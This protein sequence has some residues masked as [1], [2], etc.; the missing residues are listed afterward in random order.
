M[1]RYSQP[2]K[3]LL[4]KPVHAF[5]ARFGRHRLGSGGPA[6]WVLMY[7]RILP[8]D[9]ARYAPEEPGMIVTPSSFRQQLQLLKRHFELLPLSEWVA[10]GRAGKALPQRACAI[11][12]DDGWRDNYEYAL[13]ILQEEQ[14]PATVFA[15]AEMIGTNRQFWPNR[16]MRALTAAGAERQ[17]HFPWLPELADYTG[18]ALSREQAARVVAGCKRFADEFI[19]RQLDQIEPHW[20][21]D[22]PPPVLMDWPQ[23]Q[24][25]QSSGLVEIGSHTC[26]HRRLVSDLDASVMEREI[27]ASQTLLEQQL[28]RKVTLFCYPNGDV[29]NAAAS[30]VNAHYQAAVTT[31]HGINGGATAVTNLSRLGIHEDIGNTPLRFSARLSGW[32]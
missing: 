15:V 22:A 8:I 10:R 28:D 19:E 32:A 6:L 17:R 23:L 12:F 13:P 27:V 30:L 31:R 14:V 16:L 18:Q 20:Q 25:M 9:D 4:K 5:A 1:S 21:L 29:S 7:H 3:A 24:T 11:T 2:L 26:N